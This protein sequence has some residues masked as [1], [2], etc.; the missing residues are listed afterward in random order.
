MSVAIVGLGCRLPGATGPDAFFDLLKRQQSAAAP[1]PDERWSDETFAD[2]LPPGPP[3]R[4]DG[5]LVDDLPLDWRALRIPPLDAERMHRLERAAL[6][7][8]MQAIADAALPGDEKQR[9]RTRI[10][11]AATTFGPD[12]RTDHNRRIRRFDLQGPVNAALREEL[13]ARVEELEELLYGLYNL[14]APPIFPESL[15]ATASLLAGRISTIFDYTG[16]HV[17][18]DGGLASGLAAL[19]AAVNALNDGACDV[20]LLCG[21]SPL[22]SPSVIASFAQKGF[23]ARGAHAPFAPDST[24]AVLGEGAVAFA[25][26]RAADAVDA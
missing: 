26:V 16:G 13:P 21:V 1:L 24:G 9:A 22:L 23:V 5:C 11:I 3:L 10:F 20:A 8:L 18:V 19:Q 17:A 4:A 15:Q 7:S 12:P 14:A 25:L 2:E 6:A